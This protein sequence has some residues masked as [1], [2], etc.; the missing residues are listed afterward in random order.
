MSH[1]ETQYQSESNLNWLEIW[2]LGKEQWNKAVALQGT[3]IEF[4]KIDFTSD[5]EIDFTGYNFPFGAIFSNCIFQ[6][7]VVVFRDAIFY[8]KFVFENCEFICEELDFT[9]VD[10]I[11]SSFEFYD[12]KVTATGIHMGHRPFPNGI[13]FHK[14]DF[15]AEKFYLSHAEVNCEHSVEFSDVNFNTAVEVSDVEF[16]S[17]DLIFTR[18]RFGNVFSFESTT[19]NAELKLSEVEGIDA[20]LSFDGC[21]LNGGLHCVNSRR[22]CGVIVNDCVV[23]FCIDLSNNKFHNDVKIS[24][25]KSEPHLNLMG[26]EFNGSLFINGKFTGIPDLRLTYIKS[27]ISLSN[28]HAEPEFT[29]AP[30]FLSLIPFFKKAVDSEDHDRARR[31]REILEQNKSHSRAID[32][33]VHEMKCRRFHKSSFLSQLPEFIFGLT[34][35]YGRSIILP[36]FLLFLVTMISAC[37]YFYADQGESIHCHES[38][39][40]ELSEMENIIWGISSL[41]MPSSPSCTEHSDYLSYERFFKSVTFSISSLSITPSSRN[42]NS[43]LEKELFGEDLGYIDLVIL[44]QGFISAILVFLILLG[45]RNRFKI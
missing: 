18:V 34:S 28:M 40:I 22:C 19:F 23:K 6:G 15:K 17:S 33:H 38:Y 14:V 31:I 36:A 9:G 20:L 21:K 1:S 44:T 45:I 27:H 25:L 7:S 37:F 10:L 5:G 42:V 43:R 39:L 2:K 29:S 32:F 8:D 24:N 30:G 16:N 41:Q 12:V 3:V 4:N 26:S 13:K 35:N 11:N